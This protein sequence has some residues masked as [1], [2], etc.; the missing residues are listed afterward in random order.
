MAK[1]EIKEIVVSYR[2]TKEHY[3]QL[4]SFATASGINISD[5]VRKVAADYIQQSI[6]EGTKQ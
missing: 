3:L 1:K 6:Q 4:L 5:L 2:A